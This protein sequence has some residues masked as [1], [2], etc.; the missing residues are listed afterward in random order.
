MLLLAGCDRVFGLYHIPSP[1]ADAVD[2]A[3]DGT[4]NDG[5]RDGNSSV[6]DA[7]ALDGTSP[8]LDGTPL[9]LDAFACTTHSQCNA[10]TP[11]DCCVTPE[12]HVTALSREIAQ[13]LT[14]PL[15]DAWGLTDTPIVEPAP[16]PRDDRMP[17]KPPEPHSA[18]AL[19]YDAK[20]RKWTC[21]RCLRFADLRRRAVTTHLR[22]CEALQT[23]SSP[24]SK[25]V[26]ARKPRR[27]SAT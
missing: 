15:L 13:V 18:T 21:P 19:V 25:S 27:K 11:G 1:D 10:M 2:D 3:V 8:P 9:P 12:K 14:Q 5:N 17:P 4:V 7:A 16:P 23:S 22:F 26:K 24:T 6:H 20:T